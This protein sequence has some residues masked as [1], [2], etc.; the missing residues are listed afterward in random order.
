[1]SCVIIEKGSVQMDQFFFW[2]EIQSTEIETLSIRN[3]IIELHS[4]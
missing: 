3:S 4:S 2:L 1:M